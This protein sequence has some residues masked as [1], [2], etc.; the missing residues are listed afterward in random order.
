MGRPQNFL[1]MANF[2]KIW[3]AIWTALQFIAKVIL[4]VVLFVLIYNPLSFLFWSIILPKKAAILLYDYDA[5][6][7]VLT[8]FARVLNGW[9][10]HL[11]PWYMKRH[12]MTVQG[13]S[14]YSVRA[15]MRWILEHPDDL[16]KLSPEALRT[17]L[18][19]TTSD[20]VIKKLIEA[21][22]VLTDDEVY[23]FIQKDTLR[24]AYLRHHT[25]SD[26]VLKRLIFNKPVG[27]EDILVEAFKKNGASASIIET[28]FE[29]AKDLYTERIQK[30]L[31]TYQQ[32]RFII[33]HTE[34]DEALRKF[35][36]K[37]ILEV[38]AQ[39]ALTPAQ[40]QAYH[41]MGKTLSDEVICYYLSRENMPMA[42]LIFEFEPNHGLNSEKAKAL[43]AAST[44]LTNR[45]YKNK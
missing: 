24:T 42:G 4:G 31:V 27:T 44:I 32:R 16:K 30:A 34:I 10:V 22:V 5:E 29:Y 35:F 12:F 20:Q 9:M 14:E 37:N 38:E 1:I 15:Q 39:E 18:E 26:R 7:K 23:N 6:L 28:L 36:I 13:P 21:G 2:S 8:P 19:G 40:Y 41:Q 43:V 25:V 3:S 11:Y 33:S 17:S 45:L